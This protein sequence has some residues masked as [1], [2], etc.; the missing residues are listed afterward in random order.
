[1]SVALLIRLPPR[2]HKGVKMAAYLVR[3]RQTKGTLGLFV[4]CTMADLWDSVDE[5][6]DPAGYEHKAIGFGAVVFAA[7]EEPRF[8]IDEDGAGPIPEQDFS[9][10]LSE[11]ALH[12]NNSNSGWTPFD[13]ALTGAGLVA[14]IAKDRCARFAEEKAMGDAFALRAILETA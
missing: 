12:K 9:A 6:A 5:F 13:D 4:A 1:M 10:T 3:N 8:D 14:R 2:L 11:E 7:S